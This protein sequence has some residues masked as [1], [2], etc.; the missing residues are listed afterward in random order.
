M[1]VWGGA[2]ARGHGGC[3]GASAR[4]LVGRAVQRAVH[5]RF[6]LSVRSGGAVAWVGSV[7]VC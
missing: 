5:M 3:V 2:L 4:W 1:S 6:A 7:T